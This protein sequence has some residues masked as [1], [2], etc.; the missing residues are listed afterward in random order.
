MKLV[1]VYLFLVGMPLAGVIGIL[2]I[3]ET[4]TPPIAVGGV[5]RLEVSPP[6]GDEP[7]CDDPLLQSTPPVLTISQSGPHLRLSFNDAGRTTLVG[8][9]RGETVT[10]EAVGAGSVAEANASE[11]AAVSTSLEARI[12][13]QTAPGRLRGVL[14]STQCSRRIEQPFT[15]LRLPAEGQ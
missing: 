14:T 15:A 5:W 10:A 3:G 12:D 2:R 13:P 4:L 1:L 11:G 8:E 6:A 7:A 9:I